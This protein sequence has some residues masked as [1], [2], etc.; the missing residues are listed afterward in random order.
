MSYEKIIE[1]KYKSKID[2]LVE[3]Q[4]PPSIIRQ[5]LV[6]EGIDYF[7]IQEIESYVQ[8]YFQV[9]I[10]DSLQEHGELATDLSNSFAMI[11]VDKLDG[12]PEPQQRLTYQRM[13][14]LDVLRAEKM[15]QTLFKGEQ[16]PCNLND[17]RTLAAIKQQT[18][19]S[20][21]TFLEL[22]KAIG[23]AKDVTR[24]AAKLD[25]A[26]LGTYL[27]GLSDDQRNVALD[28]INVVM[29]T[30]LQELDAMEK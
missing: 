12:Q 6:Q 20:I 10:N 2:Q 22:K 18:I 23:Q 28:V 21:N 17:F 8:H 27:S 11:M 13:L 15:I 16:L 5:S 7:S 4:L 24:Q 14:E 25:V 29:E 26:K 1:S 9:V 30:R 19:H 3:Q